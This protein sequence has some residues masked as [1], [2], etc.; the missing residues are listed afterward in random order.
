MIIKL[1]FPKVR[2]QYVAMCE[3][4]AQLAEARLEVEIL[5]S[6]KI[7]FL[8]KVEMQVIAFVQKENFFYIELWF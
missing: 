4:K 5:S 3:E 2:L 7:S 8:M 1:P 6:P